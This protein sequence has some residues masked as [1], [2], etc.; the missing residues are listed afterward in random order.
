VE[1]GKRVVFT[2]GWEGS[3]EHPPGMSTVAI[4]LTER[5]GG[6]LLELVHSNLPAA[7]RETHGANWE[8]FLGQLATTVQGA[9]SS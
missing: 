8:H 9:Q 7:D 3:D 6:T 4:T 2:W 5:A 1:P